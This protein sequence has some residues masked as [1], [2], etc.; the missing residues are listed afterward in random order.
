MQLWIWG[1]E[2]TD[3]VRDGMD[4]DPCLILMAVP[5]KDVAD[6]PTHGIIWPPLMQSNHGSSS[7]VPA[8]LRLMSLLG[9]SGPMQDLDKG[10][11]PLHSFRYENCRGVNTRLPSKVALFHGGIIILPRKPQ[12][13]ERTRESERIHPSIQAGYGSSVYIDSSSSELADSSNS[14]RQELCCSFYVCSIPEPS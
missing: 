14:T 10:E 1:E 8:W 4:L 7:R 9:A 3:Q 2:T 11:R 12:R 5:Y 13:R 6:K